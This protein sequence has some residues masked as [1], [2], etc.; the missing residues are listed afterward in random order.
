GLAVGEPERAYFPAGVHVPQPGEAVLPDRRQPPAVRAERHPGD[1]LAVALEGAQLPGLLRVGHVP[2]PD[3]PRLALLAA[4]RPHTRAAP[5]RRPRRAPPPPGRAP[6]PPPPAGVPP[7]RARPP[8][9]SGPFDPAVASS[10][11]SGLNARGPPPSTPPP[12]P[13]F[14]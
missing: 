2:Q 8:R 10:V 11:P 6:P 7:P 4:P 3:R 14:A 5:R 12:P 9:L 13:P 1:R